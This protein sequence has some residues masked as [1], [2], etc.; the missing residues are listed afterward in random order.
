MP[1]PSAPLPCDGSSFTS[2]ILVGAIADEYAWVEQACPGATRVL[3]V[4]KHEGDR[5]FD[6]LTLE[7]TSGE[8]RQVFF[9]VTG[10]FA[11]AREQLDR[12]A[13]N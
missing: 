13:D 7:L 6:V 3:Q 1:T 9:D 2:A 10:P 11:A 5:W 8:W 12:T 4:L